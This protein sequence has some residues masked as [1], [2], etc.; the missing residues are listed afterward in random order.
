MTK[1]NINN[2]RFFLKLIEA[3]KLRVTKS[4]RAFNLVTG[5]ELCKYKK[6]SFDYRKISWKDNITGSIKQIQ[7][8]RLIWAYFMGVPKNKDMVINHIDGNK[9]N[10]SL[11]NLELVTNA[12]N[13]RHA[14]LNNLVYTPKGED[15]F[16]AKFTDDD[17]ISL[18][19][20]YALSK[21][22]AK[23]IRLSFHCS[24]PT[25][26]N[27]LAGKS[28]SHIKTKYDNLCHNKLRE[29]H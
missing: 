9:Q 26:Y 25:V 17:V 29:L 1:P 12:I 8:H 14:R 6:H 27:M 10:C 11:A 22:T 19:K 4:G 3:G 5:R 28:Y 13:N 18:R 23:Q 16:N 15:L 24:K 21:I 7:L 2:E 20:Q